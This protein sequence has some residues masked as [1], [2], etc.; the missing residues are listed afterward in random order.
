MNKKGFTLVEILSVLVLIGLLLGLAIPGINKI[1]N[2]MKKKSYSKKVS[3]VESAAELWGQDNKTLLQSSS[4]CEIKGGEKVSCYKITVGSLIENNYLDSDKNSG[5]YI[6][7]LDNSDMK[8][9]CVYVYKKN[10]R[11]YSYFVGE[12]VKAC[13]D[14]KTYESFFTAPEL[15]ISDKV[16]SG[17]VHL[18]NDFKVMVKKDLPPTWNKPILFYGDEQK[19]FYN[20]IDIKEDLKKNID[21]EIK[22]CKD[23]L[24]SVCTNTASY[25]LIIND[26]KPQI[27]DET[28]GLS[29]GKWHYK[30]F[31]LKITYDG[32]NL[33]AGY[34]LMPTGDQV[35]KE[36]T[37][38][39][40][41]PITAK[42]CEEDNLENCTD[43]VKYEVAIKTDKPTVTYSPTLTS[44]WQ[45]RSVKAIVSSITGDGKVCFDDDC[46]NTNQKTYAGSSYLKVKICGNTNTSEQ[47]CTDEVMQ[48]INIDKNAPV[49]SKNEENIS[50]YS[51]RNT[52]NYFVKNV[53]FNLSD[54]ESGIKSYII[55]DKTGNTLQTET[56]G[57]AKNEYNLSYDFKTSG[58]ITVKDVAGNEKSESVDQ[59]DFIS[60]YYFGPS[61]NIHNYNESAFPGNYIRISGAKY[62][63]LVISTNEQVTYN[64]SCSYYQVDGG[65]LGTDSGT[66]YSDVTKT[67]YLCNKN[68]S[69]NYAYI[70]L[71]LCNQSNTCKTYRWTNS[72][73]TIDGVFAGGR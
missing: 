17:K 48:Q 61:S 8:N 66:I 22:I 27:V 1:S 41:E 42:V 38:G 34:K 40:N 21:T 2:N 6:S 4:D 25:K 55:K 44:G 53:T 43:E 64:A 32:V 70:T 73:V 68:K 47:N 14:D 31:N 26:T 18:K 29:S 12:D 24:G 50:L 62:I 9:Q 10:N 49:I 54:G 59:H 63:R 51:Y 16:G 46:G 28:F 60:N 58:T 35:E 30:N 15:V 45:K 39:N 65:Q 20:K 67:I 36:I 33:N 71:K 69:Y 7:P 72:A 52:N 11:V 57:T 3:L 37:N 23:S 19:D 56:F 5:E 13:V